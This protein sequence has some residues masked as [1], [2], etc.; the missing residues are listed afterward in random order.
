MRGKTRARG[1]LT[2]GVC[3]WFS[4]IRLTAHLVGDRWRQSNGAAVAGQTGSVD[5][6][7][8]RMP[9]AGLS[10]A[11]P[12]SA[13]RPAAAPPT[14]LPEWQNQG[15]VV[16]SCPACEPGCLIVAP[17]SVTMVSSRQCPEER[18]QDETRCA[19]RPE[20]ENATQ[21]YHKN[22]ETIATLPCVANRRRSTRH[23]T[24]GQRASALSTLALRRRVKIS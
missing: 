3:C 7:G 13:R 21:W 14:R 24:A 4:P 1:N 9:L 20:G 8:R 15:W 2:D 22:T 17:Q 12:G 16:N 23:K 19:Q 5:S 11:I 10:R 6:N 18:Y